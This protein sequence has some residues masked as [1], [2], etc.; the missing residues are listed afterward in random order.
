MYFSIWR[1]SS[2]LV[3]ILLSCISCKF[4]FSSSVFVS[5]GLF[6]FLRYGDSGW[7]SENRHFLSVCLVLCD[8]FLRV[9][10]TVACY[11]LFRRISYSII[12]V[13]S[14]K[15]V[16][17]KRYFQF[18][19]TCVL[20][21]KIGEWINHERLFINTGHYEIIANECC[22]MNFPNGSAFKPDGKFS[23]LYRVSKVKLTVC[24][25]N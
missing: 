22:F 20:T 19:L 9:L 16:T 8:I 4:H 1:G 23:H 11:Y 25:T 7:W 18:R 17:R 2:G 5:K 6:G 13:F 3:T 14:E 10:S 15:F 24:L 21:F 12:S